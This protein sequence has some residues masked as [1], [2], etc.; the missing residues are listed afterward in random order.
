MPHPFGWGGSLLYLLGEQ[1]LGLSKDSAAVP[2]SDLYRLRSILFRND[3]LKVDEKDAVHKV[4]SPYLYS[5]R[6]CKLSA[7]V[8]FRNPFM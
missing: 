4:R 5:I 2:R 6:Q 7:E 8:T 1:F 3:V